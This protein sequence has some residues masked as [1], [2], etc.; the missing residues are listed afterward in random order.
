[1]DDERTGIDAARE[2]KQSEK[3]CEPHAEAKVTFTIVL[4]SLVAG[5]RLI[6]ERLGFYWRGRKP[7]PAAKMPNVIRVDLLPPFAYLQE[8][9]EK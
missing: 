1:M 4:V 5:K 2:M 9:S 6:V 8:V 3:D 7:E